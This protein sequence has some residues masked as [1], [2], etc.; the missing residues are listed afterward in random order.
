MKL[1]KSTTWHQNQSAAVTH[2][3]SDSYNETRAEFKEVS[4]ESL[5][6]IIT[7]I[8]IRLKC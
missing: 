5:Q 6:P 4:E 7:F 2:K 3:I 8:M 1:F